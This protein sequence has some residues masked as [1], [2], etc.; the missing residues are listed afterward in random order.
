MSMRPGNSWWFYTCDEAYNDSDSFVFIQLDL[1][2]VLQM[3]LLIGYVS[4]LF[5]LYMFT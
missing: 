4:Q 1:R 3:L 2:D 5:F